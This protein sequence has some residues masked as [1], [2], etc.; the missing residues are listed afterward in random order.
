MDSHNS[1]YTTAKIRATFYPK[2]ENEKSD[3]EVSLKHFGSLLMYAGHEGGA[4]ARNNFGNVYTAVGVFVLGRIFLHDHRS[5]PQSRNLQDRLSAQSASTI[6]N[7]GAANLEYDNYATATSTYPNND[8]YGYGN[9]GYEG[10]SS[11][12]CQQQQPNQSYPQQMSSAAGKAPAPG[13]AVYS[14][15]KFALNGYFHSLRSKFYQKGIMVTVVCPRPIVTSN[16][17][18][19]STTSKE[20]RV[21]SERYAELVLVATSHGLKEAWISYNLC[22][23]LC[24]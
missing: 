18:A 6:S 1:T 8:P 3:Q 13:Q 23:L 9:I 2:F 21:S 22:L 17:P 15:S 5:E 7:S 14:A 20:K 11:S 19:T 12:S 4:Y 16:A 24:T 10:Y